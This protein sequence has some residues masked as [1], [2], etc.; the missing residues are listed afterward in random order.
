MKQLF[1]LLIC[2][3]VGGLSAQSADWNP[4]ANG[5]GLVGSSDLLALLTAYGESFAPPSAEDNWIEC[6]EEH[7]T[8]ISDTIFPSEWEDYG[9]E[10]F[11]SCS[12]YEDF[13]ESQSSLNFFQW[14]DSIF[15]AGGSAWPLGAI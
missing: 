4:D 1:T 3:I 15:V 6:T 8:V 2:S 9:V 11:L 14:A 10:A 5:D 13:V 12:A 7:Y